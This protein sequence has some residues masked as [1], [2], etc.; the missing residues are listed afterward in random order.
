[1]WKALLKKQFLELNQSYF[2]DKKT[3]KHRSKGKAA[4]FIALMAA[5]FLLLAVVFFCMGMGWAAPMIEMGLDWLYFAMMGLIAI[6]LGVF[7][8]VFNTYAGLYRAKDND[9]LLSMPIPP[10]K[11]LTVRLVGV[12]AMGALYTGIVWLPI[13]VAYWL[14]APLTVGK[15]LCPILLFFLLC[16]FVLT[17][18][19]ALG[20]VVALIA[21]RI[22]NKSAVTVVLSLAFLAGYYFVYFRA[23]QY[24][25]TFLLHAEA[26]GGKIKTLARPLYE[27][28][29]AGSGSFTSLLL[30]AAAVAVLLVL[31]IWILSRSF[32]RIATENKGTKRAVY[33][34]TDLKIKGVRRALLGKELRRFAASPTYMLNCGLGLV[35]LLA[36]GVAVLLK[37]ELLFGL[38]SLL[39]ADVPE[40]DS[41]LPLAIVCAVILGSGMNTISAPSVS[42]EGKSLWL[43]QSLPVR[44]WEALRAKEELHILLTAVPCLF[45]TAALCIALH[46]AL[47]QAVC[48]F[49]FVAVFILFSADLGLLLN[50]W[51]PNLTWT[52]ET[53]PVKQSASV[54][55]DLFGV[56]AL[57]VVIAAAGWFTRHLIPP[58]ICFAVCF[59]LLLAATLRIRRWLRTRGAAIFAD[60]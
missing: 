4:G 31:T 55:L 42:L 22:K 52:N 28:G 41:L 11:I 58:T 10:V 2:R 44:P 32:V 51:K 13:T 50:L 12:Y 33:R 18:T 25:Q 30:V 38:L 7:G 23:S 21:S 60:L 16:F 45:C 26:V 27:L 56:W 15:I 39:R 47:W 36:A 54:G 6:L 53:V 20:Y 5:A 1:M 34:E 35:I 14:N 8:D 3:G 9:L 19:C 40:I 46:V 24:L 48:V 43:A 37:G 49:C 57:A 29:L 59:A 17:L